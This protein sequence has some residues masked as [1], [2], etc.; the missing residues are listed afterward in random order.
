MANLQE[1]PPLFLKL[2]VGPGTFLGPSS[3]SSCD[4]AAKKLW[5]S[6]SLYSNKGGKAHMVVICPTIDKEV[7]AAFA[8][9]D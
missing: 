5:K 9:G 7:A 6:I 4:W 3:T 1:D 2:F 8:R